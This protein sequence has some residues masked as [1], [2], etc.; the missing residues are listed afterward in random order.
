MRRRIL[1]R[2]V[3]LLV[4]L[5]VCWAQAVTIETCASA[6]TLLAW[7]V[8]DVARFRQQVIDDNLRQGFPDLLDAER[9]RIARRMWEHLILM[10]F[11][12][13]HAQRK[14]HDTNWRRYIRVH[15]K[16]EI[17][18]CLLDP[19][20]LVVVSGHFGNFEVAGVMLGLLG[21]PT[22][23]VARLLD[24]PLL[25]RYL[26]GFRALRGQF[27]LPKDGSSQQVQEVLDGGGTLVLLGDQHAGPKGCWTEFLGRP[28]SC[29]KAI[30]LFSLTA[31]APLL[32]AYARR[33]ERPLQFEL[34]LEGV[35]DPAAGNGELA[36]VAPLTR[37][38]NQML[39]QIVRRDP[40]QYWWVHRRWKGEPPRRR[41]V[42][43]AAA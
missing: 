18:G 42:R 24:N 26:N 43:S 38:Y 39:E 34:G 8:C 36:G 32:V 10:V 13:A 30:A 9:R 5:V 27:M 11:E 3:Y 37:W 41:G 6:A 14:I 12:I 17:V 35:V 40:E 21:F 33:L 28:A 7:L 1:N 15:R 23:T 20:P 4:R 29:H 2:A 25:D 22:F 31:G 16:R 19:R